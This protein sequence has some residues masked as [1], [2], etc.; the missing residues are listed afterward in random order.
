MAETIVKKF[1]EFCKLMVE[2][3]SSFSSHKS[4]KDIEMGEDI[5]KEYFASQLNGTNYYTTFVTH[6]Y[7]YFLGPGLRLS[8]D[9]YDTR[10]QNLTMQGNIYI[11]VKK[12]YDSDVEIQL[13]FDGKIY[14]RPINIEQPL[15][16]TLIEFIDLYFGCYGDIHTYIN[17][18][19]K[20]YAVKL[21]K[22]QIKNDFDDITKNEE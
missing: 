20:E 2:N 6:S 18:K 21:K 16:K 17:M 15:D 5:F 14:K 11:N 19:K 13:R 12:N 9:I 1:K 7:P 8:M 3:H 4:S 22:F 10:Y